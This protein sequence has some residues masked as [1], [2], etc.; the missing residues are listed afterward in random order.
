[1]R[2]TNQTCGFVSF[3]AVCKVEQHSH[4]GGVREFHVAWENAA[5]GYTCLIEEQGITLPAKRSLASL[6]RHVGD[7]PLTATRPAP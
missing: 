5:R 3:L 4:L 7:V 2:N 1:M 6:P